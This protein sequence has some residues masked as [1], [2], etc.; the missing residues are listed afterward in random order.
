MRAAPRPSPTPTPNTR[1]PTHT[2]QRR[3]LPWRVWRR[4]DQHNPLRGGRARTP[5]CEATSQLRGGG[6]DALLP[7]I[8]FATGATMGRAFAR[9]PADQEHHG[10]STRRPTARACSVL[11]E[12]VRVP[13]VA[14]WR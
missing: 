1:C 10:S 12:C 2:I 5:H 11:S 6:A 3:G 13:S 7:R 8:A 9:P 14:S 4:G